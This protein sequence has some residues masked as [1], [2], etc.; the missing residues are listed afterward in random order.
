MYFSTAVLDVSGF[1]RGWPQIFIKRIAAQRRKNLAMAGHKQA[2]QTPGR[3]PE[4]LAEEKDALS[5]WVRATQQ[6]DQEAFTRI[7]HNLKNRLFSL[8]YRYT[9]NREAAEDILQETFIKIY[10]KMSTITST[11]TFLPWVYRVTI[12]TALSYLRHQK[13]HLQS[14]LSHEALEPEIKDS[15]GVDSLGQRED[16]LRQAIEAGIRT[17]PPKLKT[18]FLLHDVQG[19]T[20]EEIAVILGCTV[21]TSKSQLFKARLKIRNFLKEKKIK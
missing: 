18:V 10:S 9:Y 4:N 14:N 12:N 5:T 16:Q 6:G 2:G 8:A 17:L 20:H 11:E 15:P 19:F 1:G 21:G 13:K 7:Y 3:G